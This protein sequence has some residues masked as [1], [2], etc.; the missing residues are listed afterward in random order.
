MKSRFKTREVKVG[1]IIIGGKNPMTIQ[2]MTNTNTADT[3]ATV[4]QTIELADAGCEMVRIT[5][6]GIHEAENLALIKETLL[7]KGYDVPLI[8]DIHFNPKA[9]LIAASTV[10]KVRINPGNYTDRNVG[11]A[12]FTDE[13]F[14]EAIRKIEERI[15]PLIEMLKKTGAAL[16]IGSNHGSLSERIIS[17]FGNTPA[18][19]VEAALEFVRICR[20]MDF[21][22]IVLS[23]KASNVRVMVHAT[24]LLVKKMMGEGMNYPIH[25]GVTE[26][27]DAEDGRIKSAAGIGALLADGIGDTIRVSLT[28]DPV[29]EIPVAQQICSNFSNQN[30]FTENPF[31]QF[32]YDPFTFTK[33]EIIPNFLTGDFTFPL[34]LGKT[35]SDESQVP[36]LVFSE[37]KFHGKDRVYEVFEGTKLYFEKQLPEGFVK[38]N[39]SE[40]SVDWLKNLHQTAK[41]ILIVD[42]TSK[43]P[44]GEWRKVFEMLYQV[45]L[46]IPVILKKSYSET[47]PIK[48]G[49]HAAV[50]FGPLFID[51]FGD[52]IWLEAEN[53]NPQKMVEISFQ[54][55]QACG[56]RISKTEFIACP[57]CGRTQYDIQASLQ[58][59]KSKTS[60]LPGLKIAVMGCIVNGP[61]EMADADYGYVGMGNGKVALFKGRNMVQKSIPEAEAVESLIDLIKEN[62][63]WREP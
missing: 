57:S 4:C 9:A 28:E 1:K 24:R 56:S 41:L 63:D 53:I 3:A 5:A 19:M 45:D 27:G 23:M 13:E 10:E 59:I 16:R 30:S 39:A 46:K 6:P 32:F 49:I 25:L 40:I 33:R 7:K 54:I 43:N 26:A 44:V 55:L 2:S 15:A 62:G 52:G 60:H 18:G 51:G 38:I 61:G 37:D 8:A 58:K 17:K 42:S 48:L 47:D 21:H 50:D 14:Q 29:N 36:D 22:N 12:D 31:D 11:K 20:K 34:V 35:F